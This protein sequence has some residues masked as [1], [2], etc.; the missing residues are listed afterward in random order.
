[1]HINSSTFVSSTCVH[2]LEFCSI[3]TS[4]YVYI[5]YIK[6]NC[7]VTKSQLKL[8]KNI[9]YGKLDIQRTFCL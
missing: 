5:K 2:A 1:M 3:F 6:N 8:I 9:N 7:N 4:Q